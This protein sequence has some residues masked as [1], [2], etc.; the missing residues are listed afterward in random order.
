M[1]ISNLM[2]GNL[3]CFPRTRSSIPICPITVLIGENNSGKTT[4]LSTYELLHEILYANRPIGPRSIEGLLREKPYQCLGRSFSDALRKQDG[5]GSMTL[6]ATLKTGKNDSWNIEFVIKKNGFCEQ[7]SMNANTPKVN[8]VIQVD[9]R[10]NS[11][12]DITLI[13]NDIRE[14]WRDRSMPSDFSISFFYII[15]FVFDLLGKE[16]KLDENRLLHSMLTNVSKFAEENLD[17]TVCKSIPP[18][19]PSRKRIYD[20]KDIKDTEPSYVLCEMANIK[21]SNCWDEIERKFKTFGKNSTLFQD[22]NLDVFNDSQTDDPFSIDVTIDN[23]KSN[24]VNVGQGV[25]Q[26]LP[27]LGSLFIS[28]EKKYNTFL[29]Q[30]PETHIH[31]RVEA[32]F[33]TLMA[34]TIK[35][36]SGRYKFICESHSEYII[37]RARINIMKKTLAPKDFL[38]LYFELTNGETKVYPI[39]V[40]EDGNLEDKPDSY[41]EFFL[42]EEY[43]LA[44]FYD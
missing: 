3:R 38:I 20:P 1:S 17:K 32:E 40:D 8:V 26:F 39:T 27:I 15:S 42:S 25:S 22:I 24:I 14:E 11:F 21:R 2:I 30:Q 19:E 7:I 10:E 16:K 13:T 29:I 37:N 6:G 44:G 43:R 36:H 23:L 34:D 5:E 35:K 41:N 28:D 33:S 12:I 4:F 18:V 31:P 9:I